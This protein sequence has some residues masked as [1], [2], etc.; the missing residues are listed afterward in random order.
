ML[1]LNYHPIHANFYGGK[2]LTPCF[3]IFIFYVRE[4]I[5]PKFQNKTNKKTPSVS[6]GRCIIIITYKLALNAGLNL[7]PYIRLGP[8]GGCESVDLSVCVMPLWGSVWR[9]W[10]L[11]GSRKTQSQKYAWKC[12]KITHA[13]YTLCWTVYFLIPPFVVR[14]TMVCVLVTREHLVPTDE[15]V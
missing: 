14:R 10:T 3:K 9:V 11:F 8:R 13:R 6:E 4:I 15:Q 1:K 5:V 7:Y 2:D 12:C